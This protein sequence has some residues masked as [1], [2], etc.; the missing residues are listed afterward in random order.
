MVH[1]EQ[2]IQRKRLLLGLG[3]VEPAWLLPACTSITSMLNVIARSPVW[4]TRFDF[5]TTLKNMAELIAKLLVLIITFG[6]NEKPDV[7]S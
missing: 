5:I 4:E 7:S 2:L 6:Q 3:H 1:L